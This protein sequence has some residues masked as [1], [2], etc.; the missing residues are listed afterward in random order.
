MENR[1]KI[2]PKAPSSATDH[3]QTPT[4]KVTKVEIVSSSSYQNSINNNQEEESLIKKKSRISFI[5]DLPA[6]NESE[7]DAERYQDQENLINNHTQVNNSSPASTLLPATDTCNQINAK[8]PSTDNEVC[9][10][11]NCQSSSA[12]AYQVD[13][14]ANQDH[15][16]NDKDQ[17]YS[18][19]LKRIDRRRQQEKETPTLIDKEIKPP[20]KEEGH[21]LPGNPISLSPCTSNQ[22]SLNHHNLLGVRQDAEQFEEDETDTCSCSG[23]T[24]TNCTCSD[25]CSISSDHNQQHQHCYQGRPSSGLITGNN[26]NNNYCNNCKSSSATSSDNNNHQEKSGILV[27]L[28]IPDHHYKVS[29][30]Q[31]VCIFWE[32]PNGR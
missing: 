4:R 2:I 14:S 27:S 30:N 31:F 29:N 19:V 32:T 6:D 21:S 10:I 11:K 9:I 18:V 24:C 13:E 22:S 28:S 20:D 5:T 8:D 16:H 1:L 26:N 15:H 12:S 25:I 7:G 3:Y 17:L 23:S